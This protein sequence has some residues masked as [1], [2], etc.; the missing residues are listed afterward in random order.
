MAKMP[1]SY[2]RMQ[3]EQPDVMA[4]FEALGEACKKA[5][6][7][8]AKT[9]ELV[10]LGVALAAG[11]EGGSHSHARRALALGCTPAELRHVVVLMTPTVGFP[12][13]MRARSWVEDVLTESG[14]PGRDDRLGEG[15][16]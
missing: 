7:L 2:E 12:S 6:P 3:K 1:G 15:S 10:K 16:R 11:L 13:M 8:D 14:N 4:A 5:G 9:A